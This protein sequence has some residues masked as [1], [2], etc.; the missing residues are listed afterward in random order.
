MKKIA[1]KTVLLVPLIIGTTLVLGGGAAEAATISINSRAQAIGSKSIQW[2]PGYPDDP[3]QAVNFFVKGSNNV[4]NL[5]VNDANKY[6]EINFWACSQGGGGGN[7]LNFSGGGAL[8]VLD[9]F[10]GTTSKNT[11]NVT[12]GAV[13]IVSGGWNEGNGSTTDNKVTISGGTVRTVYGG[14]ARHSGN[15]NSNTVRHNR[16]QQQRLC[17]RRTLR[18]RRRQQQCPR[19]QRWKAQH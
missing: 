12:G 2:N 10:G 19:N 13:S 15:A 11:V 5:Q 17:Q 18:W 8:S 4:L 16:R 3:D 14:Y 9:I 6:N 1:K 7:T